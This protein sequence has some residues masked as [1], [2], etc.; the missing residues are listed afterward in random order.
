[1]KSNKKIDNDSKLGKISIYVR[2]QTYGPSDYYRVIQYIDEK[3]KNIVVHDAL[4]DLLFKIN[5]DLNPSFLKKI[6]Q[7]LFF[8]VIYLRRMVQLLSDLVRKSQ[9]IVIQREIFP[10]YMPILA[11]KVVKFLLRGK[12]VVWD[13]DDNI[14]DGEISRLEWNLLENEST[15]IVLTSEYLK[16]RVKKKYWS[17]VIVLPTSDK[18]AS[19]EKISQLQ[20]KR[21]KEYSSKVVLVWTGTASNL[22]NID[23]IYNSLEKIGKELRKSNKILQLNIICNIPYERR[24]VNFVVNNIKWKRKRAEHIICRSHIGI[25]P[26]KDVEYSKGKGGFKL[27]QYMSCGLPII[28]SAVGFN[29]YIISDSKYGFCCRSADEWENALR[30]LTTDKSIW[31]KYSKYSIQNYLDNF[32][33]ANNEK[34]WKDLLKE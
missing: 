5:L 15:N 8:A 9:T 12:K 27:I 2:N 7:V 19:I 4:P 3:N 29:K 24:A 18:L 6:F 30:L 17:K 34:I 26:L 20:K 10:K 23:L 11:Y 13:F 22:Q 31:E 33:R 28:A 16:N 25:M 32:D 1:M 14:F 21:E